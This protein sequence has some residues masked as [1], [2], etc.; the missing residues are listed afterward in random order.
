MIKTYETLRQISDESIPEAKKIIGEYLSTKIHATE[1]YDDMNNCT[2]LIYSGYKIRFAHR[3][4]KDKGYPLKDVTIKS[5]SR[6]GKYRANGEEILTEY[7]K[8]LQYCYDFKDEDFYYFYCYMN[9]HTNK[10]TKYI[11]FDAKK[12]VNT[13]EFANDEIWDQQ[14]KKNMI[15]GGSL[16]NTI[17]IEKLHQLDCVLV[18][19][20][21]GI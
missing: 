20:S 5:G 12:M 13:N 18:D 4:R 16:F 7:D 10:I 8:L 9:E 3:C 19:K 17:L 6:Y 11:I 15:D 14:N 2:D 21:N 1:E